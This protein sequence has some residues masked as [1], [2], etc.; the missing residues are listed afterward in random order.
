MSKSITG[1]ARLRQTPVDGGKTEDLAERERERQ[2]GLQA[3]KERKI[4]KPTFP[5]FLKI[6]FFS[7]IFFNKKKP[8]ISRF[9]INFR[10]LKFCQNPSTKTILNKLQLQGIFRVSDGCDFIVFMLKKELTHCPVSFIKFQSLIKANP[11]LLC[12][13]NPQSLKQWLA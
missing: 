8:I 6:F 13:L 12:S 7:S 4:S 10:S 2:Y 9:E 1:S 5:L 11:S 3:W